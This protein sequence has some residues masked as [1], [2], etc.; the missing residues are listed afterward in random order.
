[1]AYSDLQDDRSY[2]REVAEWMLENISEKAEFT[3]AK[4]LRV[5]SQ[6][7]LFLQGANDTEQLLQPDNE[8]SDRMP[9]DFQQLLVAYERLLDNFKRN[10]NGLS[11]GYEHN[12]ALEEYFTNILINI[13]DTEQ[14]V[15]AD[16]STPTGAQE[17]QLIDDE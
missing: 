13:K 3:H 10:N 11:K 4:S 16:S 7:V 1:M 8:P 9:V 5:L 14:Q 2:A 6:E 12:V 15:Q 17:G